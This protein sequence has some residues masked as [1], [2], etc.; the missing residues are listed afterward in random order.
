MPFE[1]MLIYS[2]KMHTFSMYKFS[3]AYA[4]Q[5][6]MLTAI[7]IFVDILITSS[8]FS[9]DRIFSY[10]ALFN[11]FIEL[12]IYSRRPYRSS[13]RGQKST[14]FLNIRMLFFII[15]K[16]RQKFLLLSCIVS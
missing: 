7:L 1:N 12:T 6:K 5:M 8:R 11:K 14:D 16:K 4:F 2:G 15:N 3:A 9:V 10:D 13:L